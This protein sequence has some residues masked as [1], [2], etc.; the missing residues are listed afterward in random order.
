MVRFG[1]P[2]VDPSTPDRA[3]VGTITLRELLADG[4][5]SAPLLL[6]RDLLMLVT[7]GHGSH[8]VDFVTHQCRPGTLI[9]AR[10]GQIIRYGTQPA[11]DAVIVRWSRPV[12]AG[13]AA[14]PVLD[15]DTGPTH[16]QLA[17][18]D[19][20]AVINEVSQL[21]VD[22]RRHGGAELGAELLRHQLAVLLLRIA[23][24]PTPQ[25]RP[26]PT[27]AAATFGRFRAEVERT[28]AQNRRVEEYAERI[29]CVVRTLTRA[30]LTAT[31]RSAKQLLD[32]RVAL[33]AMRLLAGTDLPIA[34]VGRRLGFP[35]PTNFGRFFQRE[36]G[37]APGA[38]RAAQRRRLRGVMPGQRQPLA[39][40]AAVPRVA[41]RPV[42]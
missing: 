7:V 13:L 35:E 12:L 11:L 5:H 2:A 36:V 14:R 10:P 39:A 23:L 42:R 6:D 9:R 32:D 28:Y 17:G 24:L 40:D 33:E 4:T 8:E 20:D 22:C 37:R 34:E 31:G 16:W 30:C 27:E 1:Q 29:G 18:E 38:F 19:E 3:G 21:V 15:G 26:A 25:G 41:A